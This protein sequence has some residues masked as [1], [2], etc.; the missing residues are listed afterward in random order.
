MFCLSL[1]VNENIADLISHQNFST[2]EYIAK[3]FHNEINLDNVHSKTLGNG[4]KTVT[5]HHLLVKPLGLDKLIVMLIIL[6]G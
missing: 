1:H 2:R 4:S 3:V 5:K 6:S